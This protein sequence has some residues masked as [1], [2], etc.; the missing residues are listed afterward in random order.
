MRLKFY[1]TRGSIPICDASFQ[2]FGGNTTCLQIMFPDVNRINIIDAGTGLRNLGRDLRAI[3]HKQDQIVIAL[4]HFHWDHIQGFPFFAQA[5]DPGQKITLL[6]LGQDQTV[7]NLREIFEVQMQEEYFPVQLDRMGATFEFLQI[8]DASSHFTGINNVATVV[9]AQR[10]N[11][12]GGAYS[13]RIE[14]NGK[15]LVVCTDVEHGEQIDPRLVE[16]ARSADLL[17]HDAQYTAEELHKRRGW[18]HS[19]FDQAMQVAEMA[20]VKRLALTHHD[21]EH[22]DE[23]LQRIEKL[24]QERFPNAVLAREG[25]EISL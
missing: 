16:L 3:G 6:T 10:H 7:T 1:G 24:C 20:G 15:V 23:F 8:A 5:Y 25:M 4:T 11:H 2:Q 18:G 12:P 13:F 9:S 19:S 22:D 17:V 21:P 14:R